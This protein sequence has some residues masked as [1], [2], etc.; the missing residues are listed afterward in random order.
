VLASYRWTAVKIFFFREN[1][2]RGGQCA[3][4]RFSCVGYVCA[5]KLSNW[6][7]GSE[8]LVQR[9]RVGARTERMTF[10]R[11]LTYRV[12]LSSSS[13]SFFTGQKLRDDLWWAL[14]K[15]KR[16]LSELSGRVCTGC[17]VKVYIRLCVRSFSRSTSM[18]S[19]HWISVY[20]T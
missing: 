3:C 7:A 1:I 4:S 6:S 5:V 15:L 2:N 12:G 8:S 20:V 14:N 10:P 16:D 17:Q 11:H 13:A 18:E 19:A 9:Q